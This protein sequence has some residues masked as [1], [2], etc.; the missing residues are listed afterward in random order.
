MSGGIPR[1]INLISS[2]AIMAAFV[3]G[4][5]AIKK[6]HV[7]YAIEHLSDEPASRKFLVYSRVHGPVY[8]IGDGHCF[9]YL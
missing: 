9:R 5:I 3:S 4:N 8:F 2:R 1:L 6:N 7:N